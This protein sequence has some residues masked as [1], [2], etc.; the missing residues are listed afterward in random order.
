MMPSRDK[1]A[2][3]MDAFGINDTEGGDIVIYG[4]EDCAF[5]SRAYYTFKK[6]CH[7]NNHVYLMQGS[8]KEW[9]DAG[10]PIETDAKTSIYISQD[11]DSTTKDAKYGASEDTHSVTMDQML[12]EVSSDRNTPNSSIIIDARGAARFK[13]EVPEPR[14]GLRGGHMPGAYNVPFTTLLQEEDVT[15]F[16]SKDEMKAVF[17][18]AGLVDIEK[19]EGGKVILSCGSGVTACVLAVALSEL[20]K[21]SEDIFIYD[22]SWLEW[23]SGVARY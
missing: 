1:F 10:G 6:M 19:K 11:D 13:A 18:N 5:V 8:L 14:P 12:E 20:G 7:P 16:K 4:T 23:V 22:G 21:D 3:A 9:M 2:S 17:E 15:K